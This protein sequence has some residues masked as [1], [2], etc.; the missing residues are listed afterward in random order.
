MKKYLIVPIFFLTYLVS[1]EQ[2]L[3]KEVLSELQTLQ[4]Q[5]RIILVRSNTD[6]ESIQNNLNQANAEINDRHIVWFIVCENQS[7]RLMSN[8]DGEIGD[9]IL[10][11]IEQQYFDSKSANIIL[12]GKDGDV[13]YQA[14]QLDLDSINQRID[15]MP[16]RQQEMQER[17]EDVGS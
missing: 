5:N 13:K 11:L 16:M 7:R 8:Y 14:R 2:S 15:S 6:C 4:W 12:I 9:N 10:G 1:N 17:T 3:A